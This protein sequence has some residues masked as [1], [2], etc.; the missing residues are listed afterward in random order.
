MPDQP[1]NCPAQVHR[2]KLGNKLRK[3]PFYGQLGNSA[4]AY[5]F[6]KRDQS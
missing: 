3:M 2:A 5:Y 4:G 6:R 1:R